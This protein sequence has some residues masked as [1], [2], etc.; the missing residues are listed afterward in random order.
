VAAHGIQFPVYG[1]LS[2]QTRADYLL[3]RTPQTIVISADG[4]VQKNWAGAYGADIARQVEEYFHITLPGLTSPQK[5][6][7]PPE[8]GK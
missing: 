8:E 6:A 1:G 5:Q 7:K 2:E 3:G 4:H